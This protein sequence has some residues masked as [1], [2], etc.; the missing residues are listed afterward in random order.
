MYFERT[1][2]LKI[3][4]PEMNNILSRP[5]LEEDYEDLPRLRDYMV[6]V[7]S[8]SNGIGLA[9]PQIGLFKQ[10]VIIER[11][12][13]SVIDLVNPEVTRLYGKESEALEGCLSLP[14]FGNECYVPRMA[15]VEVEASTV[16]NP[17]TRRKFRFIRTISRIVQHEIDHLTGTFFIDRVPENRRNLVLKRFDQW[18]AMR[19]AQIRANQGGSDVVT[20]TVAAYSGHS[21]LS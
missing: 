6:E 16:S 3:Y 11:S 1:F 7:M 14:P 8:R 15:I 10:V 18:K 19:R 9:A 5:V 2:R 21:R 20:R 4:G 12:D 13:G 17:E